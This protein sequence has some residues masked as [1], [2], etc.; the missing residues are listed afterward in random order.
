MSCKFLR[1]LGVLLLTAI[2]VFSNTGS[3]LLDTVSVI[4]AEDEASEADSV[5]RADDAENTEEDNEPV[6]DELSTYSSTGN[7]TIESI[8]TE[9][10]RGAKANGSYKS[11]D[12]KSYKWTAS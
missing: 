8:S 3:S 6:S 9:I 12:D 1:K 7:A 10:Y 11:T 4:H 5:A 2:T